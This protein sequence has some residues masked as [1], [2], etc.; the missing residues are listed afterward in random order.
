MM[1]V[2]LA[3]GGSTVSNRGDVYSSFLFLCFSRLL[4]KGSDTQAFF[5]LCGHLLRLRGHPFLDTRT[6]SFQQIIQSSS[7]SQIF[8]IKFSSFDDQ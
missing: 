4:F 6:L 7:P 8:G 5:K 3:S 1:K 2:R